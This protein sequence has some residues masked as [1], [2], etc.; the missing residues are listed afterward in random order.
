MECALDQGNEIDHDR[1][2]KLSKTFPEVPVVF[3][4]SCGNPESQQSFVVVLGIVN[5]S[6]TARCLWIVKNSLTTVKEFTL[7]LQILNLSQEPT[8]RSW[9]P[10]L[11]QRQFTCSQMSSSICFFRNRFFEILQLLRND[12]RDVVGRVCFSFPIIHINHF[13]SLSQIC[14]LIR[15]MQPQ[16]LRFEF[17]IGFTEGNIRTSPFPIS[18]VHFCLGLR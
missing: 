17:S 11:L 18:Y 5:G 10:L 12:L 15:L 1:A 7:F 8:H 16:S 3:R 4:G 9:N 2:G 14:P 13:F 6:R